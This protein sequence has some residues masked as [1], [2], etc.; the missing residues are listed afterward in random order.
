LRRK[1]SVLPTNKC[2]FIAILILVGSSA[3]SQGVSKLNTP[4]GIYAVIRED[5]TQAGAL[6]GNPSRI[7]LIYDGRYVDSTQTASPRYI[8]VDTSSFV[9]LI[10]EEPPDAKMDG[11]GHTLLSVSLSQKYAG[12]LEQFTKA[13]LGGQV[14]I[15]LDGEVITTHKVRSIVQGGKFQI[16][17]CYDN[18]CEVLR[19]KLVK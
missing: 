17:R 15:V 2:L 13:H 11:H 7:V 19:A 6:S 10:L 5:S 3:F 4:N 14:A 9:P 18:A 12:R 16:T 1:T 8:T